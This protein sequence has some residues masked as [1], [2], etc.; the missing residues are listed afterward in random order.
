MG[1]TGGGGG[2]GGA[3]RKAAVLGR[4]PGFEVTPPPPI[5]FW[6]RGTLMINDGV[7]LAVA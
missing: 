7:R 4:Y 2:G 5:T 6:G 3:R 1:G